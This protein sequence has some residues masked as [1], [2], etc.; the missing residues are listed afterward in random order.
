MPDE[1]RL[2]AMLDTYEIRDLAQRYAVA[3]SFKDVEAIVELFDPEVDNGSL[4]PGREGVRKFYENFFRVQNRR[5]LLQ[6]GT[7]RVDLLG[8]DL[9]TGV[10]FTRS[11]SGAPGEGWSDVMVVY[12][13]TYRKRDGRWGFVHRRETIHA[14][15][16]SR[17]DE[18][19][20][21]AGSTGRSPLPRS[22]EYW[23]RW[24]EKVAKG[25]LAERRGS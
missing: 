4:G 17:T 12:F 8:D 13:D 9:A 21:D 15:M 1:S 20:V 3:V 2:Q 22:W 14:V 19:E 6:V 23:D 16:A 5:A 18:L 10:A 24:K 11:W 25:S 7:H